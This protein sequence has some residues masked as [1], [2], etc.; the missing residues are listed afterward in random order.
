[1]REIGDIP[2]MRHQDD[3]VALRMQLVEEFHDFNPGLRIEISRGL[4]GE[5]E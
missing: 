5:D 2:L 1:M 3:R 4:V